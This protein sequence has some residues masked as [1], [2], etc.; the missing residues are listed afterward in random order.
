MSLDVGE[1]LRDGVDRATERNAVLLMVVVAA[2]SLAS[3]AFSQ[4]FTAYTA[5]AL[6]ELARQQG[7]EPPPDDAFGS[8]PLALPLSGP[9]A[10]LLFV[11][12]AVL[13]QA[14][15]IVAIRTFVSD[16]TD[17]IP[18]AF[19]RRNIGWATLNAVVGGIV[20]GVMIL[21]GLVFLVVP[22]VLVWVSLLF[23]EQEVA[24]EDASLVEAMEE[25]WALS[26]GNR[27]EILLLAIALLLLT[28]AA[29]VPG[30]VLAAVAAPVAV[31]VLGALLGAVATVVSVAA[32]S[33]AYVQLTEAEEP[34]E[35]QD[36]EDGV[37]ALG[38]DEIDEEF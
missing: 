13:N 21:V 14:V 16:A 6:A 3:T 27:V 37:G 22:G 7:Q 9:L 8:T 34:A 36:D 4:T 12:T 17:A 1:A 10:G 33:R 31:A 35:A 38:P 32:T 5:D 30:A 23:F 29:V 19:V 18:G 24:V 11:V 26:K 25:S 15:V 28:V 2:V 20:V